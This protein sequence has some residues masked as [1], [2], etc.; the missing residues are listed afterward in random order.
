MSFWLISID[1]VGIGLMPQVRDELPFPEDG[2]T[3]DRHTYDKLTVRE[4]PMKSHVF[5]E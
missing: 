5:F 4:R 2:T 3:K 1:K